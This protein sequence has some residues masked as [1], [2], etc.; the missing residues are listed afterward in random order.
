[1]A[2][3][4]RTFE[5]TISMAPYFLSELPAPCALGGFSALFPSAAASKT[6]VQTGLIGSA[7]RYLLDRVASDSAFLTPYDSQ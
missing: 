4:P 6:Q 2:A 5:G 7:D 3:G 1:M